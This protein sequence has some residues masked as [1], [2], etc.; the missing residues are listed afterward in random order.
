MG[1]VK[2]RD[3]RSRELVRADQCCFLATFATYAAAEM[4]RFLNHLLRLARERFHC[5]VI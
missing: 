2:K 3:R 5:C 1:G 4:L